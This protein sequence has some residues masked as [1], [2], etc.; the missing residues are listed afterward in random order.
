MTGRG[1]TLEFTTRYVEPDRTFAVS[2]NALDPHAR[3]Q[4]PIV[5]VTDV[6]KVEVEQARLP[7]W[8]LA[9]LQA[10]AAGFAP[11][12]DVCVLR[13]NPA[14]P[15]PRDKVFAMDDL[16]AMGFS[17]NYLTVPFGLAPS[18]VDRDD[19]EVDPGRLPGE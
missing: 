19:D 10:H 3:E 11:N 15:V 8:I 18:E 6:P 12:G 2:S 16:R 14:C 5:V 13:V 4:S 1:E 9:S 7:A 17:W